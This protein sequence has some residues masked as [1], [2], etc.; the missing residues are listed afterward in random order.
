[1]CLWVLGQILYNGTQIVQSLK[2][3]ALAT[4]VGTV[5]RAFC[6][7]VAAFVTDP[8]YSQ[9][10]GLRTVEDGCEGTSDVNARMGEPSMKAS[11]S[12]TRKG[13]ELAQGY[14][15]EVVLE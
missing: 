10:P 11:W 8:K 3:R 15:T 4:K 6:C 2:Q 1:M 9:V 7:G 13:E 5:L 14:S 12:T